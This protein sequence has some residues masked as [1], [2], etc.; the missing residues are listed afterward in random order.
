MMGKRYVYLLEDD[1]V[2]RW[3]Q[4]VARGSVTTADVYLRRLGAFCERRKISPREFA[5]MSDGEVKAVLV[6]N[7]KNGKTFV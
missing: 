7:S 3:H 4:N 1:D 2:R 6:I 5:S